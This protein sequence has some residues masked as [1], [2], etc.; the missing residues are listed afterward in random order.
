MKT[1]R[2]I[3]VFSALPEVRNYEN[4]VC[5]RVCA[6]RHAH[7]HARARTHAHTHTHNPLL[8]ILKIN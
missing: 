8:V 5:A 4:C 6:R 1:G 2:E 7:A 3:Y